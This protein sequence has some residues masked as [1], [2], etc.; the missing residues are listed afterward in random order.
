MI[1][2]KIEAN[3]YRFLKKDINLLLI[4]ISS[5]I[6]YL[7]E[8]I[9]FIKILHLNAGRV[10]RVKSISRE[11]ALQDLIIESIRKGLVLAE[12]GADHPEVSSIETMG[13]N[14][15]PGK[16][17]TANATWKEKSEKK[18]NEKGKK[19]LMK[20][21][22]KMEKSCVCICVYQSY[23]YSIY[24]YLSLSFNIVCCWMSMY[25]FCICVRDVCLCGLFACLIR[26]LSTLACSIACPLET[27]FRGSKERLAIV[28]QVQH[29]NN[30]FIKNKIS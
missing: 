12:R 2:I 17:K 23:C 16:R 13:W 5:S 10:Q 24:L 6:L 15:M 26:D 20:I 27:R 28:L 7:F 29:G 9:D 4:T 18:E 11:S 14:E 25:V 21:R 19:N 1:E 8:R 22:G 30:S 3:I